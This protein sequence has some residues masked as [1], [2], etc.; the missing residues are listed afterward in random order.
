[1]DTKKTYCLLLLFFVELSNP[2]P[3]LSTHVTG[4]HCMLLT[5][6]VYQLVVLL[7]ICG[8]F[9]VLFLFITISNTISVEQIMTNSSIITP[10]TAPAIYTTGTGMPIGEDEVV[11]WTTCKWGEVIETSGYFT[12]C[13]MSLLFSLKRKTRIQW[14]LYKE[15]IYEPK[16]M[17]CI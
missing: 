16:I 12:H 3:L 4:R 6:A 2:F 9:C 17:A 11:P 13:M 5:P 15:A 14:N 10:D 7:A 1:M 8:S